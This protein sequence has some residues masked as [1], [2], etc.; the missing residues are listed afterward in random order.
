MSRKLILLEVEVIFHN[1][2]QKNKKK[3]IYFDWNNSKYC[4]LFKNTVPVQATVWND[5]KLVSASYVIWEFVLGSIF[6][7]A[8]SAYDPK[9]PYRM[10][11]ICIISGVVLGF[12]IRG[13]AWPLKQPKIKNWGQN[14]KF[15]GHYLLRNSPKFKTRGSWMTSKSHQKSKIGGHFCKMCVYVP[16][17]PSSATPA[18]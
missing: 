6:S 16:K 9:S 2:G 3:V 5:N 14:A 17:S 4:L 7:W 11:L 13:R 15:E 18:K 10:V 8:T 1:F 12:K